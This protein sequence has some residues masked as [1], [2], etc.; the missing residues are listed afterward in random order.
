[1]AMDKYAMHQPR[2]F[3]NQLSSDLPSVKKVLSDFKGLFHESKSKSKEYG[4]SYYS[5]HLR[6][7]RQE[8][9][10]DSQ[11]NPRPTL[12]RSDLMELLKFVSSKAND[13]TQRNT[14]FISAAIAVIVA[15][16]ASLT[17]IF[18]AQPH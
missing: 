12:D 13:E 6:Y 1:M 4:D 11:N 14:G 9:N 17:T 7:V 18:V 8:L 2:W 16:I 5:L 10:D 15:I 3:A